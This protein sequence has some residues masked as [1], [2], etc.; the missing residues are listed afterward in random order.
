[1]CMD[2]TMLDVT[3]IAHV[4]QGDEVVLIGAQ[5]EERITVDEVAQRLGTI[6]YE[7]ISEILARVPR[8]V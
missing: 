4:R 2:Q 1:V 5:G 6:H 8:V 7:V 3:D